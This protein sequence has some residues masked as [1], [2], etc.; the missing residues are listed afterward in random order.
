MDI[1]SPRHQLYPEIEP[2][3]SGHL[4]LDPVHVMYWEVSGNPDGVPVV[5][6]HGGPGAGARSPAVF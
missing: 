6:L 3:E 1:S 5:F 2:Y 4:Y